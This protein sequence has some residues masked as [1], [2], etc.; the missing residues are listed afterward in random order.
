[1]KTIIGE[2]KEQVKLA[3]ESKGLSKKNSYPKGK[4]YR[5]RK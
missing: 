4:P 2:L 1:M 5:C 3:K